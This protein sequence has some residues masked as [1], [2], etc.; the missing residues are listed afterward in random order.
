MRAGAFKR[1]ETHL[2][3]NTW[4]VN[5]ANWVDPAQSNFY[6]LWKEVN[7]YTQR[8]CKARQ[9]GYFCLRKGKP[10]NGTAVFC[11]TLVHVVD[12]AKKF[13][14]SGVYLK[15]IWCFLR[16]ANKQQY[17]IRMSQIKEKCILIFFSKPK[18]APVYDSPAL[19]IISPTLKGCCNR[20][21][22]CHRLNKLHGPQTME[23]TNA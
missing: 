20:W 11:R 6:V 22:S 13:L 5:T 23:I 16:M 8:T 14:K 7:Q 21:S 17:N 9:F 10:I 19:C 3:K 2:A 18:L 4:L 1:W 12:S 15:I